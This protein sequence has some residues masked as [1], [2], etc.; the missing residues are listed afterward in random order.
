MLASLETVASQLTIRFVRPVNTQMGDALA[1]QT[2]PVSTASSCLA[3]KVL[4]G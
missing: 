4:R 2:P 3:L 1:A